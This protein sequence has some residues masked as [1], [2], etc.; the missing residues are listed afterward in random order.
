M[1]NLGERLGQNPGNIPNS[2]P[3][4]GLKA[5]TIQFLLVKI[6]KIL[7]LKCKLWMLNSHL[8]VKKTLFHGEKSH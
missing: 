3:G 5:Q 6:P 8:M 4:D 1:G 7:L 2:A